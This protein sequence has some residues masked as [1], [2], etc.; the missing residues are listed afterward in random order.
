M[1]GVVISRQTA[2]GEELIYFDHETVEFRALNNR[3]H[4]RLNRQ[5]REAADRR[6][7]AIKAARKA[8]RRAKRIATLTAGCVLPW[9]AAAAGL[10]NPIL[11]AIVSIPCFGSLCFQA[12]KDVA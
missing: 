3:T 12:G 1:N 9:V 7:A 4:R 5:A 10:A 11:A 6:T 2:H 8:H